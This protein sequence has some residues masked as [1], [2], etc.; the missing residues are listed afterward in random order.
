MKNWIPAILRR[1]QVSACALD[2]LRSLKWILGGLVCVANAVGGPIT[3]WTT[4]AGGNG[5]FYQLVVLPSAIHWTAANLAA[6][7]AGGYLATLTSAAEN[8]F[9]YGVASQE[10]SAWVMGL[11]DAPNGLGPWLGG[12]QDSAGP[13]PAGGWAWVTGEAWSFTNWASPFEPNN[14]NG[15]EDRL[16]LFGYQRLMAPTWNDLPSFGN[17]DGPPRSYLVEYDTNP[18]LPPV[19]DGGATVIMLAAAVACCVVLRRAHTRG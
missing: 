17:A 6:Q 13:E 3:Q 9:V 16:Q 12:Y 18:A 14:W 5:H 15:L 4:G 1:D 8:T 7:N 2:R 10:S 19:P 11:R